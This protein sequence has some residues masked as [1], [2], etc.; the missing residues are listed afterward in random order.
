RSRGFGRYARCTTAGRF[1]Q[2][3]SKEIVMGFLQ[4]IPA[5]ELSA[6]YYGHL[7]MLQLRAQGQAQNYTT[8]IHFTAPTIPPGGG[9]TFEL[10]G[11]VGPIGKGTT[12][13]THVQNFDNMPF[14]GPYV[15]V[16][17]FGHPDG[18]AVPVAIVPEEA[19]SAPATT[20]EV[21]HVAVGGD[22]DVRAAV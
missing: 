10:E 6:T 1:R 5:T 13:Y 18:V 17:D 22:L 16:E 12:P 3:T 4:L 8:G 20:P 9:Y 21:R 11:W 15:T 19:A 2:P 14:P 7:R